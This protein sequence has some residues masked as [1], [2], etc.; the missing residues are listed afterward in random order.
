MN[1]RGSG[2]RSA[3]ST[4][5][6]RRYTRVAAEVAAHRHAGTGGGA[7]P[8]AD[9]A[10]AAATQ[11][12]QQQ[13]EAQRRHVDRPVHQPDPAVPALQ[14][15]PIGEPGGNGRGGAGG[16]CL[17]RQVGRARGAAVAQQPGGSQK[18]EAQR[19][20][21]GPD[22]DGHDERMDRMPVGLAVQRVSEARPGLADHLCPV[23]KIALQSR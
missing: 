10:S 5:A 8:H 20:R 23:R 4:A 2:L 1:S 19:Q 22:R 14:V 6:R 9:A 7:R 3:W 16:P 15:L 11:P 12:A 21:P 18:I 17:H 13:V